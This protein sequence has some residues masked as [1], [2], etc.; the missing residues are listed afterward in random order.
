MCKV[1]VLS[2]RLFVIMVSVLCCLFFFL[3]FN[4]VVF[5]VMLNFFGFVDGYEIG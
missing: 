4:W 2:L 3:V 1:D 5:F